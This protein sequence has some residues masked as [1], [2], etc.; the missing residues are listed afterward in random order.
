[1]LYALCRE[2]SVAG[3]PVLYEI[4]RAG[5][6][7]AQEQDWL[8]GAFMASVDAEEDSEQQKLQE[9]LSAL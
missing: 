4:H 1:M 6:S 8:P 2:V 9:H 7:P 3:G 5:S